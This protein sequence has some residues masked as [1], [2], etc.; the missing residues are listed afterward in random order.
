MKDYSYSII[1]ITPN[2][3]R[4]ES[5]NVGFVVMTPDGPDVRIVE[6]AQKINAI[7]NNFTLDNL[8]DLSTKIDSLLR[9][10]LTLESAINFFQGSITL[11]AP[12]S[13][14]ATDDKEY[15][16]N[17]NEINK[18]YISPD[19]S[20]V[21][22]PVTQKRI[23]T[24]LKNEFTKVGLLGKSLS[25][26]DNHKVVH[27]YPLAEDEGLYAE[28]LLKNGAY[29]LT[30]TLDLRTFNVK[31]RLGD[32]ALKAITMDTAKQVLIGNVKTF[33][34]YA[35]ESSVQE[36]KFSQQLKLVQGYADKM[37]N[38]LSEEDM[39]QYYDHM[40]EAA[41]INMRYQA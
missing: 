24:E 34:V 22:M 20:R 30:E 13:F 14:R 40:F 27:K 37:Y 25:E 18:L 29:H 11:S 3:V 7:T 39:S 41:G 35:V 31:Q 5:I 4:A 36:R 38:L 9:G 15:L 6:T 8:A 2:P 28:L 21:K 33:L 23:L 12:G 26:I 17:I 1:R 19:K 16:K 10:S 32:S